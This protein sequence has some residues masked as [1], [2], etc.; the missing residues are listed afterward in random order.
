MLNAVKGEVPLKLED[1]REFTLVLDF[2]ALVRAEAAYGKPLGVLL[3][4]TM[5]EFI[6][7][8]RCL[9]YGGLLAH[10]SEVSVRQVS[11]FYIGNQAAIIEALGAAIEAGFPKQGG[12]GKNSGNARPPGK[13]SG[14]SGAKPVSSR[15]RSGKPRRAPSS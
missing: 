8:G 9:L 2:E 12:E 14:G 13:T 10:H 6:G 11:D 4:D 15:A 5:H 1:G 3:A 7:A